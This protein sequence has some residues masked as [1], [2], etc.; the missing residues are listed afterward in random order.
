MNNLVYLLFGVFVRLRRWLIAIIG[1]PILPPL[2]PP[3]LK[4][5]AVSPATGWPGTIV[6]IVGTG[7][8]EG[9]DDNDVSIGNVP[10]LVLETSF[11]SLLVMVGEH[12]TTGP[13]TVTTGGVTATAPQPFTL[14]PWPDVRESAE[15][16]APVFF[17]GPQPGTPKVRVADQ[18]VLVVLAFPTDAKPANLSDAKFKE[19]ISFTAANQ[20]WLQASYGR[21]SFQFT[22]TDWVPLPNKRNFYI[23]DAEDRRWAQRKLILNTRRSVALLGNRALAVHQTA[24]LAVVA[25]TNPAAPAQV[26]SLNSLGWIHVVAQGNIAFVA[27]GVKGL[28][29]VNV[30]ANTP[31]LISTLVPG[32]HVVALDISGNTLAAAAMEAGFV[33]YDIT[34]PSA[35]VLRRIISTGEKWASAVKIVGNRLF[36]G[37][38]NEVQIYDI[39]NLA[40][41]GHLHSRAAGHWVMALDVAGGTCVAATDGSGLVTFSLAG[42]QLT[43]RSKQLNVPRLH[44]VKLSG[45]TA[46]CAGADAGFHVVSV[47]TATAPQVLK[48]VAASQAVYAVT[49]AGNRA[50][51]SIGG[52]IYA[53]ADVTNPASPAIAPEVKLMQLFLFHEPHLAALRDNIT[54]AANGDGNA[55]S[56]ALHV[57]ALQAAKAAMPWLDFNHFEG[58]AIVIAGS[59][60]RAASGTRNSVEF[61][62]QTFSFDSEKGV[63]WLPGDSHWGRKAHEFGHWFGMDDIYEDKLDNG[64][65]KQGAADRWCMSGKHDT[66]PLFAA[67][68]AVRMQL[69]EPANMTRRDWNPAGGPTTERFE[70]AAHGPFEDTGPRLHLVQLVVGPDF[71]YNIEVRQRQAANGLIFDRELPIP[72]GASR[73]LVTRATENRSH[74]NSFEQAVQLFGDPLD[75]GGNVV[76]AA[77]LLRIEVEARLQENPAVFRVAVHWNETPPPDANG[78]F[79]L[80]ITPWDTKTWETRDI[81]VNSPKNDPQGEATKVEDMI[82]AFHEDGDPKRPKLNGDSPWVK[83]RNTIFARIRNHGPLEDVDEVWVTAYTT[84]PPGI[85]DNGKWHTVD[86]KKIAKV[87][88]HGEVIVQFPWRPEADKHT[89]ISIAIAPKHRERD[90]A[91]NRAQENVMHFDS[92][93]GSSHQPAILSAE[94]RSPFSV[95]RKVDLIV[96]GLPAGW[97]AVVEHAWTWLGPKGSQPMRAVIWTDLHSPRQRD[98]RIPPLALARIEGWTDTDYHYIPIGGILAAVRANK[99]LHLAVEV[100]IVDDRVLQVLGAIVPGVPDV[101]VVVE[102]TGAGGTSQL[103]P[104][105]TGPTGQFL[106]TAPL[107]SGTYTVQVFTES[108]AEAAATESKPHTVVV[109]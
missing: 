90:P 1:P 31:A 34:N 29:V 81:W 103:A 93:G 71:S 80:A 108:T 76:D 74:A 70:I 20:F 5:A 107:P 59:H 24:Q 62:G 63:L 88:K 98:R 46:F 58:V 61:E 86:S 9:L 94:V 83:R 47:A 91:N 39:A 69:F 57:H 54:I 85:G 13:V 95:W 22:Y 50:H 18:P 42:D 35:P 7:F 10:A 23:W 17:H 8:A 43:E 77:R 102:I 15:M 97:H 56:N 44:D 41:P 28:S 49:L 45:T 55:K 60:G 84:S 75:V 4:I 51:L 11:T 40:H 109:M 36:V 26:G 52:L 66:G 19:V 99:R 96:R 37:A 87:P 48:T 32:G 27:G 67:R 53:T 30:A 72:V 89:C 104:S 3:G 65:I 16:G 82:Y 68:E 38:R 12:A 78:P 2:P 33:L 105:R 73:V 25:I 92:A 100:T 64:T 79:D 101:P 6:T 106:I 14:R 21:T